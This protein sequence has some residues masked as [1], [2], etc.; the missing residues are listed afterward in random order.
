MKKKIYV[1]LAAVAAAA[2]ILSSCGPEPGRGGKENTENILAESEPEESQ[3]AGGRNDTG[4]TGSTGTTAVP[5]DDVS[6]KTVSDEA[7]GATAG[8]GRSA[9]STAISSGNA[10]A[11]GSTASSVTAASTG[12]TAAATAA[13]AAVD[14]APCANAGSYEIPVEIELPEGYDLLSDITIMVTAEKISSIQEVEKN[15]EASNG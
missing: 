9:G 6:G 13:S 7:D 14:L 2:C 1:A 8:A 3:D 12:Q 15:T 4:S 10:V 5:A 11:T